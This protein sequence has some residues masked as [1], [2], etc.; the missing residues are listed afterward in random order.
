VFIRVVVGRLQPLLEGGDPVAGVGMARGLVVDGVV[1]VVVGEG[2]GVVRAVEQRGGVARLAVVQPVAKHGGLAPTNGD[3]GE[4]RS[5]HVG[6]EHIAIAGAAVGRIPNGRP[7]RRSQCLRELVALDAERVVEGQ[8]LAGGDLRS[9]DP[10]L[11][12]DRASAGVDADRAAVVADVA[13][14]A[15][16][17]EVQLDGFA[18]ECGQGEEGED[19]RGG[20]VSEH[21]WPPAAGSG[22]VLSVSED[23]GPDGRMQGWEAH[24][25]KLAHRCGSPR[26]CARIGVAGRSKD[27]SMESRLGG[28]PS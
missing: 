16:G 9:P 11:I 27:Q 24:V 23:N 25:T 28:T 2:R 21:A 4:F 8:P 20:W 26:L 1:V 18:G 17:D 6:R 15:D 14:V 13:G 12:V 22:A 10:V 19:Q 3:R 5:E 7:D